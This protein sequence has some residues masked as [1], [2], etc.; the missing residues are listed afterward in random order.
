[1]LIDTGFGEANIAII[2][3]SGLNGENVVK[4]PAVGSSAEWIQGL[5][6]TLLQQL[7][8]FASTSDD[9]KSIQ[10]PLRLQVS[11][12]FRGGINNPLSVSGR[13]ASGSLQTGDSIIVRPS[14]EQATIKGIEV[15]CDTREWAVA[16]EICT[17]HLLDIDPQYLRSGDI[18]CSSGANLPLAQTV[19]ARIDV[20]ETLL[21]QKAD[22]H[23]GRLHVPVSIRKLLAIVDERADAVIKKNPRVIKAGQTAKVQIALET[24]ASLENGNR[25]ILRS[26]GNTIASGTVLETLG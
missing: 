4:Q 25:I 14:G 13:I 2:P 20:L 8:K 6:P 19:L 10:K 22:L 26:D 23:F 9:I 11:D 18:V 24:P 21:P 16:S 12:V 15:G 3:C 7:E 17:L 5:H 1:V